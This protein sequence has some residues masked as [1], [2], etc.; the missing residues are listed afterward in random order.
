M[1]T[2]EAVCRHL[3]RIP[4]GSIVIQGG[5]RGAD[6]RRSAGRTSEA[7]TALVRL[8]GRSATAPV[9]RGTAP[10]SCSVRTP[11][12]R[13]RVDPARLTWSAL[14]CSWAFPS[15][16]WLNGDHGD[17]RGWRPCRNPSASRLLVQRGGAWLIA[18]GTPATTAC[19]NTVGATPRRRAFPCRILRGRRRLP[20]HERFFP[21]PRPLV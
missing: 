1:P 8:C 20:R 18:K 17:V 16:G 2:T 13:F 6:A 19:P 15:G 10:C 9:P 21:P 12:W 4:D 11:S 14:P 7:S 3:D 5:A